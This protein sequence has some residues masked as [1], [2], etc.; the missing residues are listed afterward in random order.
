MVVDQEL[1][2]V[3]EMTSPTSGA[4]Y[5]GYINKSQVKSGW[6]QQIWPDGGKYEG[7]W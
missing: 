4:V 5:H 6:G 2:M 7:E 3:E 1:D